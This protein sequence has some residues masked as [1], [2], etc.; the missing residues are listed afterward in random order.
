MQKICNF[1]HQLAS[2]LILWWVYELITD[3]AV[4][5]L[6]CQLCGSVSLY[7]VVS[8]SRNVQASQIENS[9]CSMHVLFLLNLSVSVF[10]FGTCWSC[11]GLWEIREVLHWTENQNIYHLSS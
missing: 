4:M 3:M 1:S 11:Q 2:L 6:T 8:F 10:F 7:Q 5:V 9:V